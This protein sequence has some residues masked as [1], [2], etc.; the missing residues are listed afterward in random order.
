MIDA[1]LGIEDAL[2]LL[3]EAVPSATPMESAKY[4]EALGV[5]ERSVDA[6]VFAHLLDRDVSPPMHRV[7]ATLAGI[8]DTFWHWEAVVDAVGGDDKSF[9][10]VMDEFVRGSKRFEGRGGDW[11]YEYESVGWVRVRPHMLEVL[12]EYLDDS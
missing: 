2:K 11:L 12:K 7:L 1:L 3:R 9:D 6:L 5:I 4:Y 8:G 10:S